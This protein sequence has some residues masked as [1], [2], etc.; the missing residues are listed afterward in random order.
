MADNSAMIL[1]NHK[2][3]LVA[4]L[5]WHYVSGQDTRSQIRDIRKQAEALDAKRCVR[6]G[7]QNHAYAGFYT[8]DAFFS[9]EERPARVFSFAALLCHRIHGPNAIVVWRIQQGPRKGDIAMV[10]IEDHLPVADLVLPL[11]E[12]RTTLQRYQKNP[13]HAAIETL[14]SNDI[15]EFPQARPIILDWAQLKPGRNERIQAIPVDPVQLG[16]SLVALALAV[17]GVLV[18]AEYSAHLDREKLNSQTSGQDQ[19]LEYARSLEQIRQRLGVSSADVRLLL[20]DLMQQSVVAGDW[21]L[22]EITCSARQCTQEWRSEGGYTQDILRA[23][24]D[25]PDTRPVINR[26][27]TQKINFVHTTRTDL[28]GVSQWSQLP[29]KKTLSNLL[30]DEQQVWKKAGLLYSL[31][32]QGSRWPAGFDQVDENKSLA[33]HTVRITGPDTLIRN[34]LEDYDGMVFWDQLRI[35]VQTFDV[36]QA[37]VFELQGAFYAY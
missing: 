35:N 33:R 6:L 17:S 11:A 31:D 21:A 27:D 20:D 7:R 24:R 9:E 13:L 16:T 22:R 32:V 26:A 14:W 19:T 3:G 23:L 5:D 25:Q 36:K 18:V 15:D 37:V 10:V 12:A 29:D 8:W 30:Y 4:G 1:G 2:S 28:S 34:F